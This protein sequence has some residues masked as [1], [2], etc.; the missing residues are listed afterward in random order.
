MSKRA[1]A[2]TSTSSMDY[3]TNKH[4]IR[5]LPLH[6]Y[7]EDQEFLD[8]VEISNE[9]FYEWLSEN[10]NKDITS[11]PPKLEIILHF[12][13]DLIEE[14]YDEVLTVT[15]SSEISQTY[16]FVNNAAKML[17]DRI[18]IT[19]F[20]SKRAGF[21]ES[22]FAFAAARL[23]SKGVPTDEIIQYLDA[24]QARNRFF[25]G[26]DSSKTINKKG[27]IPA[28]GSLR[29]GIFQVKPVL[30]FDEDGQ[31][32]VVAK[33]MSTDKAMDNLCLRMKEFI[34]DRPHLIFAH[35]SGI[36]KIDL[37]F[38][39]KIKHHLNIDK[40]AKYPV[41]PVLTVHTGTSVYALGAFLK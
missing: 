35:T 13:N 9:Y 3:Y 40:L 16:E 27:K 12:F 32:N 24:M 2:V 23:A 6:I 37:L 17:E 18:K 7:F 20:D 29:N 31:F 1:I 8:V 41:S 4:N 30:T 10:P 39:E 38:E 25:F 28:I 11:S 21:C 22:I 19:V 5:V 15:L 34:D 26:I 14:G 36:E 33:T